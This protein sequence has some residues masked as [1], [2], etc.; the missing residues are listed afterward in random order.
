[1]TILPDRAALEA[2]FAIVRRTLPPTPQIAWPLLAARAG[3]E[4]WLKHE[5][6]LPTGAF[7]VRGGL[8]HMAGLAASGEAGRGVICATRGN[9]GQSVAF[10][11]R[12]QGL[13]ATIVVPEGNAVEKNRAMATLGAEL[14][15]HGHDFQAALEF[16]A[17]EAERR[18]LVMVP[19]FAGTLVAG[20]ASYSMELFAALPDLDVL[21][22]PIGLGSGICGAIAARE[23]L[24]LA[25]EIVGVVAAGAPVYALSFAAGRPVA[26]DTADNFADG[27]AC[28]VPV[29]EAV[30]ILSRHAARIVRVGDDEIRAAIRILWTD[31]HNG[32]E[33]AGAAPLAALL[34]ERGKLAGKRAAI[35]MSGGNLDRAVLARVL[36]EDDGAA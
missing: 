35:V 34:K 16:A 14:V 3:C 26:T 21:Y 12:A 9:H 28:R 33:G 13:A 31:T 30:D 17:A 24:G 8:V 2:A 1:M 22:V 36:A 7:K 29:A 19:S 32:A 25:T 6:H 18:G 20:V 15:V 5:N 4:L 27:L 10:A 11:A 23:A